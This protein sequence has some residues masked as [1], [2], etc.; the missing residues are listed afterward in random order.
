MIT[1]QYV[2]LHIILLIITYV[3]GRKLSVSKSDKKYWSIAY[4]PILAFTI[5]EGFRW[6]REIDWCAYYYIYQDMIKGVE[7]NHEPF[8]R[9]LWGIFANCEMP[10]FCVIAFCSFLLIYS[11]YFLFRPHNKYAYILFPL[12]ILWIA[13][14]ATNLIRWYMALSFLLIGFRHLLDKKN[15]KVILFFSFALFTHYGSALLIITFILVY[16]LKKTICKPYVAIIGSL[17]L[18]L[19]FSSA[20]MA[21]FVPFVEYLSFIDRFATYASNAEDWLTGAGQNSLVD[22]KSPIVYIL[23]SIPFYLYLIDG[24]KNNLKL[25]DLIFYNL[26]IIGLLLRSI[27]S[28]L[29]LLDRYAVSFDPFLVFMA[30]SAISNLR[31][32]PQTISK[33][34]KYSIIYCSILIQIYRFCAPLNKNEFMHYIWNKQIVP[35]RIFQKYQD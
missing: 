3:Y 22:K 23:T 34:I 4:I 25:E 26:S 6:G 12:L 11:L 35:E 5:E 31:K 10:Y 18:I 19:F 8:F 9:F 14:K 30:A 17:I 32:S 2:F 15:F 20:F 13:P 28:G 29:E 27:S 33:K 7:S 1:I 21:Q 24:K 16:R